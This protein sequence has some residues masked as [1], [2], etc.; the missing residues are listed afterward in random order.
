MDRIAATAAKIAALKDALR[1]A[2]NAQATSSAGG[3]EDADADDLASLER[4][5]EEA[6]RAC[7]KEMEDHLVAFLKD[8]SRGTIAPSYEEWVTF[9]HPENSKRAPDGA[10]TLDA[11]F[12]V[13]RSDHRRLWNRMQPQSPVAPR[14]PPPKPPSPEPAVVA[15][16]AAVAAA[17][18]PPDDAEL[19]R[20]LAELQMLQQQLIQLHALRQQQQ[21]QQF[22]PPQQQPFP[23]QPG[24]APPPQMQQPPPQMQ[25]MQQQGFMPQQMQQP[26]MQQMQY[27]SVAYQAPGQPQAHGYSPQHYGQQPPQQQFYGTPASPLSGMAPAMAPPPPSTMSPSMRAAAPAEDPFAGL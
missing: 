23:P 15:A 18:P 20:Q 24:F 21:M 13:D 11:R 10:I 16:P 8:M 2:T 17:P 7:M 14:E 19:R 4:L 5:R 12:Y 3:L 25:Q 6:T 27:P 26:G 1:G 9:L 22:P